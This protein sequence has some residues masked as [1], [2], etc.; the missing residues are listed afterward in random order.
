MSDPQLTARPCSS[1][2]VDRGRK[3][4]DMLAEM[5]K[6]WA[7]FAEAGMS[8]DMSKLRTLCFSVIVR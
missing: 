4:I 6:Y 8:Q 1:P 7:R 3:S 5:K 2:I